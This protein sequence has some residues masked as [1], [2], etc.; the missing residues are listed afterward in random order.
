MFLT[1]FQSFAQV[2]ELQIHFMM[3]VHGFLSSRT[4]VWGL[5]LEIYG[6]ELM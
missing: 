4:V 6:Q 3:V 5:G 1:H 2:R